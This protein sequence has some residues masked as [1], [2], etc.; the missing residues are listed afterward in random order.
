[1]DLKKFEPDDF[2]IKDFKK[3]EDAVK[4]EE[5]LNVVNDNIQYSINP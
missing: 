1:M 2:S 5:G 4:N 3:E